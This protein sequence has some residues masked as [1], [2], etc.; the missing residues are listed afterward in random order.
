MRFKRVRAE[1]GVLAAFCYPEVGRLG[2]VYL[3]TRI[4]CVRMN[5]ASTFEGLLKADS[6]LTSIEAKLLKGDIEVF[7]ESD[8]TVQ[9]QMRGVHWTALNQSKDRWLY[10]SENWIRDAFHVI[11]PSQMTKLSPDAEV[12]EKLLTRIAYFYLRKLR[13]QIKPAKLVLMSKHRRHMMK[14]IREHLFPQIEAGQRPDVEAEWV[15]DTLEDVERWSA[16]YL[17][18]DNNDMQ[19]LHAVGKNLLQSLVARS[20]L[21][22]CY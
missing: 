14:W 1:L 3:P 8:A 21:Y 19:L 11:E 7:S 5:T 15:N 22:R 10:A 13:D 9:V 17:A 18:A 2:T 6:V 20:L 16:S 12:F 4:D